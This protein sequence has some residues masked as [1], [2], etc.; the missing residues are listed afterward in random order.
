MKL[1]HLKMSKA[2]ERKAHF[3]AGGTAKTWRPSPKL[4]DESHSKAR[5]D[6]QACRKWSA[7][8]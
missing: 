1:D 5:Q 4:L 7:E 6:K 3:A 2:A 8:Y